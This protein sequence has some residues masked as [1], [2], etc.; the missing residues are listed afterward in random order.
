MGVAFGVA[1]TAA[2]RIETRTVEIVQFSMREDGLDW[3]EVSADGLQLTLEGVAPDEA[4]RFRAISRALS[5]VESDRIVDR[6][7]VALP[8]R[9]T[10]PPFSLQMLRNDEGISLIGLVP[11]EGTTML[12]DALPDVA[13]SAEVVDM[14]ETADYPVPDGW[15]AAVEFGLEA[16]RTL[17]RAKVS[18][19]EGRVEVE[20]V[21][22]SPDERDDFL[23]VLQRAVP[24]GVDVALDISAPR[25][26]ITP[27]SLRFVRTEVR[28][29]LEDCSADTEADRE[30][31]IAAAQS[32]GLVGAAN[33]DIGL[34]IPSPRWAE[35]V[36][37]AIAAT[38]ELGAATVTFSDADVTLLAAVDTEQELFD[39]VVGQL[40][41]DL[42]D[43]FSLEAILP[44]PSTEGTPSGPPSFI[45]TLSEEG[46]VA[47]RGRLPDQRIEDVVEAFA[48][49]EFGQENV[50]LA[51][52]RVDDLPTGWSVRVLAGLAALGH[53]ENGQVRIEPDALEVRGQT[54]ST[55][56]VSDISRLLSD[57]LGAA[58]SFDID[59]D[60]VEALDPLASIP[61]PEECVTRI[62]SILEETKITFDPG[63]VEINQ[64][65]GLVLDLIADILPDCRHAEIEIG[66]HTDD[67]GREV[68]NLRLSQARAEA[69][70][71]GLLERNIL[72]SNL[73]AI[74]Y[75]ETRPIADNDT[76]A[77]RETNRRIEFRL[78]S[79][80]EAERIAEAEALAEAELQ[81]LPRP[82]PRPDGA[83]SLSFVPDEEEPQPVDLPGPLPRP[84]PAP[85]PEDVAEPEDTPLPDV[86][87]EPAPDRALEA[88][89]VTEAETETEAEAALEPDAAPEAAPEADAAAAP[90]AASDPAP[91]AEIDAE[92]EAESEPEPAPEAEDPTQ[93]TAPD[94]EAEGAPEQDAPTLPEA[95]V[96]D[97]DTAPEAQDA[98]RISTP[99][100]ETTE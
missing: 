80:I 27:F 84:G 78:R 71:N 92:T 25:P 1:L 18:V 42:P 98:T 10:A 54:G 40:E 36:E 61:T 4:S 45:A 6:L 59:V 26:V 76:E 21:S 69:V 77:G 95:A 2:D 11:T 37:H 50:R 17:P 53:L 46:D 93:D 52:R 64:N 85:E 88:V 12:A 31:I 65:A 89:P 72:V 75:G 94:T 87:P 74:G 9:F 90:E 13:A 51:T 7:G 97:T 57:E 82:L 56:A 99:E 58:A 30:R 70:L 96:D 38:A 16:L 24:D 81:E 41:A 15:D 44:E 14:V 35:A 20:A 100:E 86:A 62:A 34:G 22:G 19:T 91:E 3:V 32:A 49:A 79:E 29:R 67:Q 33:C 68:M 60:Y 5:L 47:L 63:S 43:V 55:S 23:R 83:F 28:A 39:R 66:G 73:S 48:G 8:D